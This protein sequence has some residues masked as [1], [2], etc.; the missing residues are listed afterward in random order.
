M[1]ESVSISYSWERE[2]TSELKSHV[3]NLKGKEML[4]GQSSRGL[5]WTDFWLKPSRQAAPAGTRTTENLKLGEVESGLQIFMGK[6]HPRA[7]VDVRGNEEHGNRSHLDA[8]YPPLESEC[9]HRNSRNWGSILR[10]VNFFVPYIC[11]AEFIRL[12]NATGLPQY[13]IGSTAQIDRNVRSQPHVL[14]VEIPTA[15][16]HEQKLKTWSCL[17][18]GEGHAYNISM[19]SYIR[20]PVLAP[21]A[22]GTTRPVNVAMV[23]TSTRSC[24]A[25]P[26][27]CRHTGIAWS[28]PALHI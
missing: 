9:C 21:Y 1:H 27:M 4:K 22:T 16:A 19:S 8:V 5:L 17:F 3:L 23:F 20:E 24:F 13:G 10:V 14:V 28:N 18:A 6:A 25:G 11:W 7:L 15:H 26:H 12:A 2:G